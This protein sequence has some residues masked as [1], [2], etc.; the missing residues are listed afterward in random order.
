MP[1]HRVPACAARQQADTCAMLAV[2]AIGEPVAG[3]QRRH[4][5]R[6]R[7]IEND[8]EVFG[9]RAIVDRG[10]VANLYRGLAQDLSAGVHRNMTDGVLRSAFVADCVE[11][12]R[13]RTVMRMCSEGAGQPAAEIG[14]GDAVQP[15][16]ELYREAAGLDQSHDLAADIEYVGV[17]R[18]PETAPWTTHRRRS[19]LGFQVARTNEPVA[20]PFGP[21]VTQTDAVHHPVA[22]EPVVPPACRAV[23]IRPDP[24]IATI[25]FGRD[26]ARDGEFGE[27][28]LLAQ[29][30]VHAMQK[31]IGIFALQAGAVE[32]CHSLDGGGDCLTDGFLYDACHDR[33]APVK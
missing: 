7:Q 8:D 27:R 17:H 13:T 10:P 2:P 31:G 33:F 28:M 18:V 4:G 1:H 19:A 21:A 32:T 22:Q 6:H 26:C 5:E 25:E 30:L 9:E 24:D 11:F 23:G 12:S 14:I 29:R 16:V 3:N 15:P 20:I